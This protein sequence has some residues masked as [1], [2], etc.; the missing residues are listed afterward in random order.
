[1]F[2]TLNSI[3]NARDCFGVSII[4]IAMVSGLTA[5]SSTQTFSGRSGGNS[6]QFR[7]PIVLICGNAFLIP[8]VARSRERQAAA[9][10]A[11]DRTERI[12]VAP[13]KTPYTD[14]LQA[15]GHSS[16]PSATNTATR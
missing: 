15:I 14:L 4:A 3:Q 16:K 12:K 8:T 5:V 7:V 13:P 6:S 10:R 11:A 2:S 9:K 1:M